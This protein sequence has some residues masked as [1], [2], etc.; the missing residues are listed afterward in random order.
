MDDDKE[1]CCFIQENAHIVT[2]SLLDLAESQVAADPGDTSFFYDRVASAIDTLNETFAFRDRCRQEADSFHPPLD[3]VRGNQDRNV[4][5]L[6]E[7][8]EALKDLQFIAEYN[9]KTHNV[10]EC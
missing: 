5:V 8:F 3:E 9:V 10:K 6:A 1:A 2:C 7:I 4:A